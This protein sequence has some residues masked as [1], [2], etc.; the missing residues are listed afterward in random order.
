MLEPRLFGA[1]LDEIA[2]QDLLRKAADHL[3][4]TDKAVEVTRMADDARRPLSAH[5]GEGN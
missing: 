2:D 1:M 4:K 5:A 3:A